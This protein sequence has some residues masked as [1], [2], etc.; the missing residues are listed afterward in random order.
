MQ[1]ITIIPLEWGFEVTVDN[2]KV[3]L[4]PLQMSLCTSRNKLVE[5]VLIT[6]EK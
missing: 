3:V 6:A 2:I 1:D 5:I 4:S